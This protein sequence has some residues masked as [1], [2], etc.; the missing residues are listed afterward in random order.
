M[1][2]SMLIMA[3]SIYVYMTVLD[4]KIIAITYK[5][6]CV[7][8]NSEHFNIL[9]IYPHNGLMRYVLI[10]FLF[11]RSENWKT[12]RLNNLLKYYNLLMIEA[13]FKPRHFVCLE[14]KL[15]ILNWL[16]CCRYCLKQGTVLTIKMIMSLAT[17][18]T[19]ILRPDGILRGEWRCYRLFLNQWK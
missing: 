4:L 8:E 2:N 10:W 7:P 6:H 5:I 14:F 11:Y 18:T 9:I 1:S 19:Y 17:M 13:G 3:P 16:Y 15:L 12:G